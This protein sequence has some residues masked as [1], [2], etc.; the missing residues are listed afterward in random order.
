MNQTPE[1]S[2]PVVLPDAIIISYNY[3]LGALNSRFFLELRDNGKIG[4]TRCPRCNRVYMPPRSNCP[5]CFEKLEEWVTLD[6]KGTVLSYTIVYY[7]VP[8]HPQ[9]PPLIYGLIQLDGADTSFV[10]L[11]GEVDLENLRVGMRVEAVL[12][13]NREGGILDIRHFKPLPF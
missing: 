11:L 9:E 2:S 5:T 12:K 1:P 3:S 7:P 6:S 8:T 13:E 10:H 4:G